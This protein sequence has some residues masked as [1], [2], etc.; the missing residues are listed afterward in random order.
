MP[1]V[2]NSRSTFKPQRFNAASGRNCRRLRGER[3][4]RTRRWRGRSASA[5]G[6]SGGPGLRDQSRVDCCALPPG[7][8]HG[9]ST[10]RLPLGASASRRN[11]WSGKP[12][13]S[14]VRRTHTMECGGLPPLLRLLLSREVSLRKAG[15]SSRTPKGCHQ[16]LCFSTFVPLGQSGLN[17]LSPIFRF[18]RTFVY[19]EMK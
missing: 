18:S 7:D 5:V 9:W 4:A 14:D 10:S 1:R 11:C 2:W 6:A 15:A 3:R 19:L 8:S 17:L 13:A 12:P 16:P